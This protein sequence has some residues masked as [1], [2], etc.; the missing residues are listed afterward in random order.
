[1]LRGLTNT[2]ALW[3]GGVWISYLWGARFEA[4]APEEP[5]FVH[6]HRARSQ[7][8]ERRGREEAQGHVHLDP[9]SEAPG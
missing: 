3:R 7:G 8:H 2:V 4:E 9:T 1:M 5:L 6:D